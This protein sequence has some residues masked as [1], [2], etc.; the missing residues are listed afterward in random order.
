MT[1][2]VVGWGTGPARGPASAGSKSRNER[3]V[4]KLMYWSAI[5]GKPPGMLF[6]VKLLGPVALL[7]LGTELYMPLE[8]AAGVAGNEGTAGT[9]PGGSCPSGNIIGVEPLAI[10]VLEEN[11]REFEFDG[12]ADLSEGSGTGRSA[13]A[14]LR[15][16][17]AVLRASRE[18]L[19]WGRD[20][21]EIS[22]IVSHAS[23]PVLSRPTYRWFD[24][25]LWYTVQR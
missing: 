10:A 16:L 12:G 20:C 23:K 17:E 3:R 7:P 24:V 9:N 25:N 1:G 6:V 19:D 22:S 2:I 8:R 21:Q 18:L 4:L 15:K 14:G 11:P 13:S 5:E